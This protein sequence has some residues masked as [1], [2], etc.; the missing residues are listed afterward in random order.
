MGTIRAW[1]FETERA[2][3][4]QAL[5]A[6]LD[7]SEGMADHHLRYAN[8]QRR[9]ETSRGIA[10]TRP[11]PRSQGMRF[12]GPIETLIERYGHLGM[13]EVFGH[14]SFGQLQKYEDMFGVIHDTHTGRT[15]R[16]PA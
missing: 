13:D 6:A 4:R 2:E 1:A 3:Q 9:R 16:L 7:V 11:S 12:E 14:M 10:I 8:N 15:Y 5:A